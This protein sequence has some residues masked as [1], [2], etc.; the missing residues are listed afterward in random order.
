LQDQRL[1]RE[2]NISGVPGTL[3][4]RGEQGLIISG[5]QP[6]EA[7]KEAVEELLDA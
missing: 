7:L 3:M 4:V 2:L 6:Y 1:A 5:T